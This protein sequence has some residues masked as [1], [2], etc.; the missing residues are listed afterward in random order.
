MEGAVVTGEAASVM[1]PAVAATEE[2]EEATAAAEV[3][4]SEAEDAASAAG[5]AAAAWGHIFE[6]TSRASVFHLCQYYFSFPV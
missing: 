1:I 6:V 5:A 2:T 3:A 4:A